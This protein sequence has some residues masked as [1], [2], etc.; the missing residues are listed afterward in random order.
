MFDFKKRQKLLELQRV[1]RRIGDLTIPGLPPFDG[2]SRTDSRQ[3]RSIPA[4]LVPWESGVPVLADAV[5]A[6]TKDLSD[7]G[8]SI[9]LPQPFRAAQVVIG[10]WPVT[11]SPSPLDREPCFFVGEVR[12]NVEIGGGFWQFGVCVTRILDERDQIARLAPHAA[13]LVPKSW[14]NTSSDAEVL[15]CSRTS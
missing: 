11:N 2:E 3:N 1:L 5:Y 14:I 12:Q 13:H 10:F 9:I 15:A 8:I 6:M 7:R 4:L